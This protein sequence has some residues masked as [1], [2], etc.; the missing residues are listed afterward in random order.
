MIII[1]DTLLK[2]NFS[3][4]LFFV[5]LDYCYDE[6]MY[7]LCCDENNVGLWIMVKIM[8]IKYISCA[9]SPIWA[10]NGPQAPLGVICYILGIHQPAISPA[11]K[12]KPMLSYLGRIILIHVN[13]YW[14]TRL[15]LHLLNIFITVLASSIN[16]RINNCCKY[17]VKGHN[18][19]WNQDS[20]YFF[21]EQENSYF[22]N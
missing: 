6:F 21:Q 22:K 15:N 10:L 19:K 18:L 9:C 14:K 3:N 4:F 20:M 7:W 1:M 11:H 12:C 16:T 17:V 8:A 5:Y 2:S 13:F